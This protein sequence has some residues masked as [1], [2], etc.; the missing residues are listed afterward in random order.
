[1]TR[2]SDIYD[3]KRAEKYWNK[4]V[5]SKDEMHAVL[6]YGLPN[7]INKA[8]ARWET[9]LV[10]DS[11]LNVE[12]KKVLDL[13]CGTGRVSIPLA[14]KGA[15]VTAVDI[16]EEMLK[17][18]KEKVL[19]LGI[20]KNVMFVKSSVTELDLS[21]HSF[22][23]VLCL[24]LLEHIPPK[25][26]RRVLKN[27]SKV[28]KKGTI[29]LI[30]VNNGQSELLKQEERYQMKT[31]QETGYFCSLMNLQEIK[32]ILN[33]LEFEVEVFGSNLFYSLAKYIDKITDFRLDSKKM[34]S[35]LDLCSQIDL[36]IKN[37]GVSD[38]HF[39]DQYLIKATKIN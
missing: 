29:L 10:W 3:E 1:M 11:L 20:E 30:V 19:R 24:G 35:L 15:K 33:E 8:Y 6:S 13:G 28:S 37:K 38:R 7:H 39:S 36:K 18:F 14:E 26:R 17:R 2:L 31:Q 16:S 27:I 4:R 9:G 5:H 21:S 22:D 34:S 23:V 32:K 25:I 12:E